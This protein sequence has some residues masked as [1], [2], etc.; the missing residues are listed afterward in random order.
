LQS[1]PPEAQVPPSDTKEEESAVVFRRNQAVAVSKQGVRMWIYNSR[2]D[3]P[4]AAVTYQETDRGHEE[5]FCHDKSAFVFYIIEGRGTWVIE[6]Q[7]YSVEATDVVIVPPG[8]RFYYRGT[9]KQVCITAPAWD[10][11][12]ERHVRDVDL[13]L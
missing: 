10:A 9:L 2:E 13:D 3:C 11:A 7:E 6:D 4:H 1:A 5:E 12:Y 8:K